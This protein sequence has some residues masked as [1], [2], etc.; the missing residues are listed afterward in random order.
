MRAG[1]I[2]SDIVFAPM[3]TLQNDTRIGE[4][5]RLFGSS[6]LLWVTF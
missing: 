2:W 6:N 5:P 1:A 4:M 3:T